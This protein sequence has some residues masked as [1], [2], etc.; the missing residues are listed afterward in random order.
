MSASRSFLG[1]HPV[2]DATVL[3]ACTRDSLGRK[4]KVEDVENGTVKMP[5]DR[6]LRVPERLRGLLSQSVRQRDGFVNRRPVGDHAVREP[7]GDGFLRWNP[8]ARKQVLLRLEQAR[9]RRPRDG[10][11]VSR[12]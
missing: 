2:N 3:S 6:P 7:E 9:E 1:K 4:G 10:A 5:V 12:H 11:P 8:I